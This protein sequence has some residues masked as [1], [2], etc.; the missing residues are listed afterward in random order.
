M[1]R[2]GIMQ[3][4][5]FP[6]LGYFSLMKHTDSFIL[7][8]P[9]QFIRHGWIERNR[10]LKQGDEW[11]YIKV[12]LATHSQDTLIK[13]ILVDNSQ[14]W[15]DKIL[16]QLQVYKKTAPY[17]QEVVGLVKNIFSKSYSDITSLNKDIL[18]GICDYLDINVK[19]DVF[20]SMKLDIIAPG[21]A[22]EWA[23]NICKALGDVDEYWNPP[24]GKDFFD[25]KKYADAGITLKFQKIN[26][27]PYNQERDEF[28]PGLSV[29]DAMMFN[30]PKEIN[31]M[32]DDYEFV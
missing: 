25:P 23:L 27:K 26:L 5:F 22:D 17:Y 18:L 32:L 30:T 4:Y 2:I 24:G 21:E 7:F 20:S 6:Y 29:L 1:K 3:P 28:I 8:D 10:I 9:V 19:L 14:Q 16:S 12:P 11:L 13:D 31:E 15:K